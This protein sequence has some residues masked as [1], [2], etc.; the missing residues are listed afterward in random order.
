MNPFA[1]VCCRFTNVLQRVM[2]QHQAAVCGQYMRK[3]QAWMDVPL[4]RWPLRSHLLPL[5]RCGV[6]ARSRAPT[7]LC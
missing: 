6:G 1:A 4:R 5:R 2:A 3:G 7:T